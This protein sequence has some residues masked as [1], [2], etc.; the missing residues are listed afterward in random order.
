MHKCKVQANKSML[1][2]TFLVRNWDFGS[3]IEDL[4]GHI[5]K[6]FKRIAIKH[7]IWIES[8]FFHEKMGEEGAPNSLSFGDSLVHDTFG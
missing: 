5:K 8:H 7:L 6:K 2:I 1:V 4:L 3:N